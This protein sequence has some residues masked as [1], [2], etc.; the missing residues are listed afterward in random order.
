MISIKKEMNKINENIN[1]KD[2][3]DTIEILSCKLKEMVIVSKNDDLSDKEYASLLIFAYLK[4]D[5]KEIDVL[6]LSDKLTLDNIKEFTNKLKNN[7]KK[8]IIDQ[9]IQSGE[10]Y[11]KTKGILL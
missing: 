7:H 8:E 1:K 5:S 2:L 6:N 4:Y 10:K 3:N 11:F 9:I